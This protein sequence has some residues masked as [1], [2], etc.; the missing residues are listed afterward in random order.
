MRGATA[1]TGIVAVIR[2]VRWIAYGGIAAVALAWAGLWLARECGFLPR[3][4]PVATEAIGGPFALVAGDGRVVTDATYRGRWLLMFFGY[5]HCPDVCPMAM[6]EISRALDALGPLAQRVQ[7]LFISVDPERDTPAALREF[8]Q[9]LDPRIEGL[10]G[11]PAQIADAARAYRVFY[12]RVGDG[13]D[14]TVDHSAVIYAMDP[15]GV[16]ATHFTH[17]TPGERIAERMRALIGARRPS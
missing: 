6:S 8:F 1:A 2:A 13:P 9:A 10:S 12:R 7:P 5:T 17:E 15:D 11:S 14:Y 4:V 16:F 3:Q